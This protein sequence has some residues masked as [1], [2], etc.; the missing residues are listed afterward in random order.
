MTSLFSSN[1]TKNT[2][3]T[4]S[5]SSTTSKAHGMT[6]QQQASTT[7]ATQQ[8]R[9]QQQQ[10]QRNPSPSPTNSNTSTTSTKKPLPLKQRTSSIDQR[11]DYNTQTWVSVLM[12]V[13]LREYVI[14]VDHFPIWRRHLA[15]AMDNGKDLRDYMTQRYA[16][17]MVFMSL[18]LS[19]ELGVLFNSAGV[20]SA[21][22]QSLREEAHH[23]I[24]FWTGIVI[25]VSAIL[26]LLSLISTFTAWTMVSAISD[27]N[28]HCILR[29]SIGQYVAELPGRFIVG[30]I[31]T[32]LIWF[33]LFVCLLLPFG[34]YSYLILVIVIC[35]FIH[36]ITAFSAFGR[37]IMHTGAMGS[38]RIFDKEY[39][40]RLQPHSLHADL[41]TKAKANLGNKTSIIRQYQ[42]K[43]KPIARLY[44]EDEMSG[45]LSIRSYTH[46]SIDTQEIPTPARERTESLVKFADGFDTN[47]DRFCFDHVSSTDNVTTTANSKGKSIFSPKNT[48]DKYNT[49]VPT[50]GATK[51]PSPVPRR[52][53]RFRSEQ[54]A[55]SS[56]EKTP[57]TRN[58]TTQ[59]IDQWLGN[60]SL[61]S[62]DNNHDADDVSETMLT[63]DKHGHTRRISFDNPY[64]LFEDPTPFVP[65][66][67][68]DQI[69]PPS[70]PIVPPPPPPPPQ[71]TQNDGQSLPDHP[72]QSAI[73]L[74]IPFRRSGTDEEWLKE[75]GYGTTSDDDNNNNDY[76]SDEE[77][78]LASNLDQND[79]H[80][81]Y[82][83]H[84]SGNL[85]NIKTDESTSRNHQEQQQLLLQ[86]Q[87]HQQVHPLLAPSKTN[88]FKE[89]NNSRN[90]T[91]QSP[92]L[93]H[94]RLE[95]GDYKST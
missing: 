20:T 53:P 19:T 85:R 2:P 50:A 24:S 57:L 37:V 29:S 80:D 38:T 76:D 35:L 51:M 5:S 32:F 36:T 84:F 60:G 83:K 28:A 1:V 70:I 16:A 30:S 69:Q 48:I 15:W 58:Q 67:Q 31:Y 90:Q 4:I 65:S 40:A 44:S 74:P 72:S 64:L 39:E 93:N 61:S 68:Q 8:Q 59:V 88:Q 3:K 89:S 45:H 6:S 81:N 11:R 10:Q 87:Q 34:F 12:L 95:R 62:Y 26:T 52:P 75:M 14:T 25:I 17:S 41:L 43:S 18:L 71:M 91:E 7:S 79:D 22:R 56:Q 46:D 55:A 49:H 33:C 27:E 9:Q 42:M 82:F 66:I 54:L 73:K 63:K 94:S 23:T 21:I 77:L 78:V 13:K 86:Q 92:L 47:G